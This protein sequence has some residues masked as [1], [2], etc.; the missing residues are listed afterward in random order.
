[1]VDGEE[2]DD[3]KK[4]A[5]IQ[6]MRTIRRCHVVDIEDDDDDVEKV[7]VGDDNSADGTTMTRLTESHRDNDNDQS[8]VVNE[9]I[10]DDI[11]NISH[12]ACLQYYRKI[13]TIQLQKQ[14]VNRIQFHILCRQDQ[15]SNSSTH[16]KFRNQLSAKCLPD[17]T[18]VL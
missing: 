15:N 17:L 14:T 7:D 6:I 3:D 10:D 12:E 16:C 2:E 1:M 9:N 11:T 18:S 5:T 13:T 8:N 4:T